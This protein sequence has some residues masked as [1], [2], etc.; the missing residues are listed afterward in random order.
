MT[1][2]IE[3]L[4]PLLP[5]DSLDNHLVALF[6][7]RAKLVE[8]PA[9]TDGALSLTDNA[10]VWLL[11]VA[12]F[13]YYLFVVFAYGGHIGQMWK[14]VVGDNI[15]IRV[16]DELSYLFM[17]AVRNSVML[18]IIT[19]A[20]V[21]VGWLDALGIDSLGT[22]PPLWLVPIGIVVF[23]GVGAV[24]RILTIGICTLTRRGEVAQ[25]L[26]ILA[27]TLMALASLVA[28]PIALL[29]V[30]NTG[31]SAEVLGMITVGVASVALAT[32]VTKSL[33]FFLEQKV[34]ILLWILYLCAV[35]LIPIGIVATLAVRN[36]AI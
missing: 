33:I 20:L 17:R 14:I 24:Q 32:F 9:I 1:T 30:I 7:E 2:P 11:V 19:W 4:T 28:T 25:G 18:G 8:Q 29:F 36:G 13:V 6:G 21:G 5:A 31:S 16:A 23:V 3:T 34:S 10:V 12:M 15:G 35:I 22:I 26:N 27:D